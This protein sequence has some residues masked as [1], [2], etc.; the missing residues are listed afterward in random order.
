MRIGIVGGGHTGTVYAAYLAHR[1]HEVTV[2]TRSP[3]RWNE[4]ISLED[5]VEGANYSA[6]LTRITADEQEFA[7]EVDAIFVTLP[8]YALRRFAQAFAPYASKRHTLYLSPGNCAREYEVKP[9]RDKDVTILGLQRVVFISRAIEYGKS[10]V[11][12]G[13]KP[14]LVCGVLCGNAEKSAD[15]E[16]L[17]SIPV[18]ATPAYLPISLG[19]SNPILHSSR[20]RAMVGDSDPYRVFA[21]N[22]AFYETWDDVSSQLFFAMDAERVEVARAFPEVGGNEINRLTDYYE[23]E[24]FTQ[25]TQKISTIPA[26]IGIKSPMKTTAH[27]FQLD[28]ASRYFTEDIAFGLAHIAQLGKIVN[29]PTPAIS[30]MLAWGYTLMPK[31]SPKLDLAE[32]GFTTKESILNFYR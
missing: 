3:K 14:E 1:G 26:F 7:A 12:S 11:L 17:F 31:D 8:V 6:Q 32:C 16:E 15:L 20:L 4:V 21:D 23:S 22:L 2:F 30:E 28:Y 29:I 19:A 5:R 25:L 24:N 9:L 27:G 10:A 13:T 18:R